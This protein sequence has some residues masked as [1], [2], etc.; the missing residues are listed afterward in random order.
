MAPAKFL[1]KNGLLNQGRIFDDSKVSDHFAIIPTEQMPTAALGDDLRI[2]NLVLRRFLAAFYPP[3]ISIEVE[4][5]TEVGSHN[6][7]TRS[8][9]LSDLGWYDVYGRDSGED[10]SLPP[11]ARPASAWKK[12]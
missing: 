5:I 6:F 11:S 9:F 7:R 8:R 3:A 2:Y 12:L 10:K 1:Q 4:R